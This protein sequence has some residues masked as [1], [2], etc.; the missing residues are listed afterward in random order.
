[1]L[2][3][4]GKH[5]LHSPKRIGAWA[6]ITERHPKRVRAGSSPKV[7]F[8]VALMIYRICPYFCH[9]FSL[10]VSDVLW[11]SSGIIYM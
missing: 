9:R 2:N 3:S 7:I 1:M 4:S 8:I 11:S 5:V 6:V 10:L